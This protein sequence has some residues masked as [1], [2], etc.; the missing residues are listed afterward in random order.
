MERERE[1]ERKRYSRENGMCVHKTERQEEGALCSK[2]CIFMTILVEQLPGWHTS[3]YVKRGAQKKVDQI[4]IKVIIPYTLIATTIPRWKQIYCKKTLLLG[5]SCLDLAWGWF[6]GAEF[7][8][9]V[10]CKSIHTPW[11]LSRYNHK[12]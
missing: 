8:L 1:R 6:W 5:F 12:C 10:S 3:Q 11:T 9:T 7:P 2:A 4:V